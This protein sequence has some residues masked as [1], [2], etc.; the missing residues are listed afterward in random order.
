MPAN[1]GE[2][3]S[4]YDAASVEPRIYSD[5]MKKGY[6]SPVMDTD[7]PSFCII[8]PPPNVTGE[9]HLGHALTTAIEDAL[10][11]WHRMLGEST[12]W[13]PGTDHAGIATQWVVERLL[14]AE[15]LTRHELGREAFL[16]RVWDWVGQYGNTING[17][18]ERLGAS[19]D[20][21]RSSFT[22]DEG[23]AKAV[24]ATFVNLYNKGLIYRHERI[25]NWC[26][27]CVTALS[28]LEVEYE[29]QDG[30]LFY[31]TYPLENELGQSITVATTRPE[32]MLGDT[33]VAVHP[34]DTR[35]KNFIGK[36]IKLP[37]TSRTI[38]IVSDDS[39]EMEFGTGALKVTPAHD[40]VDFD[41]G[42][43]NNLETITVIGFDGNMTDAAGLY[44]GKD[45]FACR[46]Q[47]VGDLADLG[48]L[49]KTE[50]LNHS[51]GHCQRCSS[52]VE[53]L[54]SLQWFLKVGSHSDPDSIAGRAYA[55]VVNN[56]IAIVPDRFSRVYLNWLEN[57]RDWCIS[58]QLWWGHRIPVWYCDACTSPIASVDDVSICPSC[59]STDLRQDTDVLDT[60]FSS[61]L[62]PHST[63]GWPDNSEDLRHFYPGSVM[64][65]GYDILFFWVARMIMMGIENT[66]DIPFKTVFLHGL[67]RDANGAKMSK[68][69][70]NTL[71]PLELIEK[72][73]TDALRFALTT[74]TAPGNDLRITDGKL[75][76][77]RNFANK[78]WNASR[79]VMSN[80]HEGI[81]LSNWY[82]LEEITNR[83][84]RWIVSVL[85]GVTNDV[86]QSLSNFELGEAQQRLYDF[87]WNDYC[88]WYIEMAKIRIRSGTSPSPL[89]TL[90]H[91]LDQILRLLHPFMPF[92]T[93]EIW[94]ILRRQV[95]SSPDAF[96]SIM[97][98]QYPQA[99]LSRKDIESEKEISLV[100]QVIKAIRN[101]R[102]QLH[103][104]P[105]HTL[106]AV[107]EANGLFDTLT[108]ESGLIQS[109]SKIEPLKIV[110]GQ[111][112]VQGNVRG[113]S[114]LVN[115]LIVRLPLEGVVDL[116]LEKERL[117][118][119]LETALQ[120]KLRVEK[121]V[122]NPNF[123]E[124]ARPEVVEAEQE[125]LST[126]CEQIDRL[127]EIISQI[128]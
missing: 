68:T 69:R 8:M 117:N 12:L 15:G 111:S 104:A 20:W 29:E 97:I 25:I 39:I 83:E 24:K 7:K 41:I 45:R 19:C 75:E 87:V 77:A 5:W 17:Q 114:L 72:Y 63:L 98:S 70:G 105:S 61:G 126:V 107:I 2:M 49:E 60:W 91:V 56:D 21:S 1:M 95:P 99:T 123:L 102:S 11:R 16:E 58:R 113:I 43:R 51:V 80:I 55:A 112:D 26:P 66:G 34:D 79:Y 18:L 36:N 108:E 30:N 40:P 115:P 119:E 127:Q 100:T 53:P 52:V 42:Q 3:A 103:I 120:N 125:R 44:S 88:D 37:L 128:A 89:P 62:W 65:T 124:K 14:A 106:E 76:S 96:E 74:G 93:E 59:G 101:T 22:L 10:T 71:D 116:K 85:D 32:S 33:G 57:I 73:G 118:S 92:I 9:L 23:P 35:Y 110:E 38:P 78:V 48:L 46:D 109:L 54:I 4:T 121:L 86:N 90:V 50:P 47:I 81:D 27:R 28:D 64:E 31:I 94:Q 6:F 82:Q 13:L 67:V 122:A 84:D